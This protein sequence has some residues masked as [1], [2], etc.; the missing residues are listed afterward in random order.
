LR[1]G[2]AVE[3]FLRPDRIVIGAADTK[4]AQRV[5]SLYGAIDAPVMTTTS[6]TAELAK[7]AANAFLATSVSFI[8][9]IAGIAEASGAD[10]SVVAEVLRRDKRIGA[11]AYLDA[12][13]GFGGSCL[14]KD[15]E[16]LVHT[17]QVSDESVP[18]LRAVLETNNARPRRIVDLLSDLFG[19]LDGLDVAVLGIS[20][21]GGTFDARSSPAIAVVEALASA[22]ARVRA[23][24][25]YANGATPQRVREIAQVC[26]DAYSAAEGARALVIATDHDEFRHL[27]L[28]RIAR[29]MTSHVLIDGRNII[30]PQSATDAGFSYIGA[31]RPRR[32]D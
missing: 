30:E 2:R 7:Y 14:P 28:P 1:E 29:S 10:V 9:E 16:A 12:G 19:G 4:A 6:E 15:L 11:D 13:I 18:L 23:Y 26:G 31:G 24:D 3:D 21:K 25:P 27:D 20:F 17:A 8:N 5:A 22:G 32:G